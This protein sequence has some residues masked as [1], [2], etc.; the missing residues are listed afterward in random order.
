MPAAKRSP[1]AEFE[2]VYDSKTP[3]SLHALVDGRECWAGHMRPATPD[4]LK[5]LRSEPVCKHCAGR[6]AKLAAAKAAQTKATAV[7]PERLVKPAPPKAVRKPATRK[8]EA[9]AA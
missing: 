5:R 9:V 8:V 1:L 4:E 3:T 7:E 6:I 2:F